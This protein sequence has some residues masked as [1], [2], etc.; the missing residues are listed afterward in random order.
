M[1]GSPTSSDRSRHSRT[2]HPAAEGDDDP[3]VVAAVREY[4]SALEAGRRPDRRKLLARHPEIAAELSDCLHGLAL[5]ECAA[6]DIVGVSSAAVAGG[7]IATP[8]LANATAQPLGDFKLVREIGRGGMG[9]VYEAVQMSLGRRVAVKV[10]P[11]AGALDPRQ[12]QRFRNEAQAAAQLHHTNIVPVHAVG[13]ERSVHFYAMQYIEGQSLAEVIR[14]MRRDR[15][16]NRVGGGDDGSVPPASPGASAPRALLPM[17]AAADSAAAPF[18]PARSFDPTRSAA[19]PEVPGSSVTINGATADAAARDKR[20]TAAIGPGATR[21]TESLSLLRGA[22]KQSY[23][24]AVARLGLQAAEGLEY[25]HQLGVVHRDIKPANLL[26][27]VQ[28]TLWITDFGLAQL[29]TDGGLTQPGDMLGTFRYMS[30]EQA[31]GKAVVL[32]QRTDIYSLG[33]TLYEL[34]TLERAVRGETREQLLYHIS[35]ID[36]PSP[37][38]IDRAIPAEL[39]TILA[40]ATAKEPAERYTSARA[41]AE[42]LRRFLENEPILARPP[43]LA[44]RTIKWTRRHKPLAA[45]ALA[46]LLLIAVALLTSTILIAREQRKTQAAYDAERLQRARAEDGYRQAREAVDFFAGVATDE[47]SDGWRFFEARKLLL[48]AAQGSYQVLVDQGVADPA[49]DAELRAAQ[50][51]IAA[52]VAEFDAFEAYGKLMERRRLLELGV[53]RDDLALTPEQIARVEAMLEDWRSQVAN[54]PPPWARQLTS[55]EKQAFA[56]VAVVGEAE[57]AEILTTQQS[58]RLRQLLLHTRGAG[59]FSDE[60]V[61]GVL[62]LTREQRDV[63]RDVQSATREIFSQRMRG[64]S[65]DNPPT[66]MTA[67]ETEQRQRDD[68]DRILKHLTPQQVQTWKNLTGPRV[69][70]LVRGWGMPRRER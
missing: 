61:V 19:T 2:A 5:M 57:I 12:L 22:R 31:S 26:L 35:Y 16:N 50:A 52:I 65:G 58:H 43:S 70:G 20:R 14:E 68:V 48:K 56:G 13:C 53:V 42:D 33:L 7:A 9:V 66:P 10:L 60:M 23:F 25:A 29:Q 67:E 62:D 41:L 59:A 32:D 21:P 30:P 6:A 24:E 44:D 51:R 46:M 4:L 40:K 34:L 8:D 47:M 11:L 36:P 39:E 55:E 17:E 15:D 54:R 69:R 64:R 18:G 1:N 37:R 49:H 45:S 27:D 38:S 3:R 28:G 63:V